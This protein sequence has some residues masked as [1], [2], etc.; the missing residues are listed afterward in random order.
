MRS[1][2]KSWLI[3]GAV[4]LSAT[5]LLACSADG[6]GASG[7]DSGASAQD[8]AGGS[9]SSSGNDAGTQADSSFALDTGVDTSVAADTSTIDVVTVDT[10]IDAGHVDAGSDTG[11]A[12]DAGEGGVVLDASV[13]ASDSGLA[14]VGSPCSPTNATQKQTCGLCGFQERVCLATA[15]VGQPTWQPWGFCQA[16]VAGGCAPG[17]SSAEA[18]GLCGTRAKQCQNDC[19]YAVGACTGQPQNACAPG[20]TQ[21]EPG[22]SCDAG[23]RTR[24]CDSTCVWG[25]YGGCEVSDG[26]VVVGGLSIPTIA[27]QTTFG[28]FTLPATPQSARLALGS[29]PV[30]VGS[31]MTS[32]D[33]VPVVNTT[34]HA[35]TVSIW[36]SQAP[37]AGA[38]DI[39]TVI[40]VY[41]RSTPPSTP[42]ERQACMTKV[43]DTCNTS[44]CVTGQSVW[45]G[46][47]V[48]GDGPVSIPAHGTIM[49][50]SAAYFSSD[51]GDFQLNV[52]TE[53]LQ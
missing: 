43:N 42:A 1:C 40:G 33:Y 27:G 15:D 11:V 46:L 36:H 28:T 49:V 50:Y 3:S 30:T 53:T 19:T 17:T 35:A 38:V 22:L 10:G 4:A 32:F 18:C 2:N 37:T 48:G 23:G 26:G 20:T 52:R 34:S 41:N 44:P 51:S 25:V 24:T 16:E 12:V 29:C 47:I 9:D 39:D 31:S 8:A 21:Y 6:G 13:D 7:D 14:A 45:A 5:A